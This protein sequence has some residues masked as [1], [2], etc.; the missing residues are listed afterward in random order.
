MSFYYNVKMKRM[1]T[2]QL[3]ELFKKLCG[4]NTE[5]PEWCGYCSPPQVIT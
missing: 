5:F 3:W 1:A 2:S 4:E